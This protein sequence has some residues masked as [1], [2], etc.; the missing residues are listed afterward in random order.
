[1]TP[2]TPRTFAAAFVLA[3]AAGGAEAQSRTSWLMGAWCGNLDVMR[4][5]AD[6]ISFNDDDE[7]GIRCEWAD[8]PPMT[9]HY[10]TVLTCARAGGETWTGA[11]DIERTDDDRLEAYFE[12]DPNPVIYTRCDR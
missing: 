12:G 11:I 4:V 8:A 3:L 9:R 10:A 1:M 5:A 7:G 2:T 6:G